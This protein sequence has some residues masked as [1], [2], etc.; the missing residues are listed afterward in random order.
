MACM[1]VC[2]CVRSIALN[3]ITNTLTEMFLLGNSVADLNMALRSFIQ[4]R[5]ACTT[6]SLNLRRETDLQIFEAQ[7]PTYS[8]S[9]QYEI[10]LAPQLFSSVPQANPHLLFPLLTLGSRILTYPAYNGMQ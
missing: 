9:H 3:L 10:D 4:K 2:V 8:L 1:H 7:A 5:E 6:W